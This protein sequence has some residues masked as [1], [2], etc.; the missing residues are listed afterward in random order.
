MLWRMLT[1]RLQF[2]IPWKNWVWAYPPFNMDWVLVRHGSDLVRLENEYDRILLFSNVL[3]LAKND[4]SFSNS[5][6]CVCVFVFNFDRVPPPKRILI[7]RI[8]WKKIFYG[9]GL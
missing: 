3:T 6:K 1:F 7:T 4:V 8:V 2:G 5:N 9:D